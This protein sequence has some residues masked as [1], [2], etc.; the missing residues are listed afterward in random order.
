MDIEH[1]T[2]A[3]TIFRSYH[4][5]YFFQKEKYLKI[6]DIIFYIKHFNVQNKIV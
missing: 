6:M 3:Q 2:V 1:W 4:Y 5:G